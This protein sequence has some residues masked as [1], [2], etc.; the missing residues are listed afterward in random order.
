MGEQHPNDRHDLIMQHHG[1]YL[2]DKSSTEVGYAEVGNSH[3]QMNT[4]SYDTSVD[5]GVRYNM[6]ESSPECSIAPSGRPF[7]GS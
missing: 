7:N 2:T 4:A 1:Y 5:A 3:W 6:T